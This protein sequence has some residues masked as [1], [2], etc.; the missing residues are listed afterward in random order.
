MKPLLFLISISLFWSCSS[1]KVEP[2]S[3]VKEIK[4]N[5][6]VYQMPQNEVEITFELTKSKFIPGPFAEYTQE[7]LELSPSKTEENLYWSISDIKLQTKAV[8]DTSQTYLL[9][10]AIDKIIPYNLSQIVSTQAFGENSKTTESYTFSK[11]SKLLFPELTLKQLIIEDSK[12]SYKTVTVDS[13]T[14]KIPIV[15]K[16]LRNKTTKELAKDAAKIITKIRKRRFRLIGG[17]NE[18]FPKKDAL[19]LMLEE[20]DKKEQYYLELFMG[21]EIKETSVITVSILPKAYESYLL[22][23]FTP[24]KGIVN[25]GSEKNAIYLNIDRTNHLPKLDLTDKYKVDSKSLPYKIPED[26][27]ISILQNKKNLVEQYSSLAQFGK[28]AFLPINILTKMKVDID[29]KTGGL[30]IIE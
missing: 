23:Y 19:K 10:G 16:V 17:L 21:R 12:T 22:F 11:D 9:S 4:N 13:I 14:K 2:I 25:Q 3:N 15:N 7:F 30:N 6:I 20:L 26:V 5:S 29:G 27:K 1:L 8:V 28:L 18:K 24:E